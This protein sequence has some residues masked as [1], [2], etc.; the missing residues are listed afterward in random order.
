M[1]RVEYD[2]KNRPNR[3]ILGYRRHAGTTYV[4]YPVTN[5]GGISE[6]QPAAFAFQGDAQTQV[7]VN[8][9]PEGLRSAL[10]AQAGEVLHHALIELEE[11]LGALPRVSGMDEA[12]R[13]GEPI[14]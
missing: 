12:R 4:V 10:E 6:L 11:S 7:S 3:V 14:R 8:S 1:A 2:P 9:I 13:R 5:D